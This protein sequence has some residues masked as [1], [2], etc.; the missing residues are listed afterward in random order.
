MLAWLIAGTSHAAEAEVSAQGGGQ[1]FHSRSLGAPYETG[2]PYALFLAMMERY[3]H[4]LGANWSEFR[5][6]FGLLEDPSRP[7]GLPVGFVLY[8]TKLTATRFLMTNCLSATPEKSMG[9]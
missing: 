1:F 5:E 7:A 3:P 9:K 8:D 6:N 2:I 4:Q